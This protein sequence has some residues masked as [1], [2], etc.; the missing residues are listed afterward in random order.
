MTA[1][2]RCFS[3][4]QQRLSC[5]CKIRTHPPHSLHSG[6]REHEHLPLILLCSSTSP[7]ITPLPDRFL[8]P[9]DTASLSVTRLILGT[10]QCNH[11][12]GKP[13]IST[14]PSCL[15]WNCGW[16]QHRK[17]HRL[18]HA[19][20]AAAAASSTRSFACIIEQPASCSRLHHQEL[21]ERFDTPF[22]P[23]TRA[24]CGASRCRP[25]CCPN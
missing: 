17:R 20:P 1:A 16:P 25:L 23:P 13:Q 10:G 4:Q 12:I 7:L 9:W 19:A 24:T 11:D 2:A 22:Q 21:R 3:V 15:C 14:S 8:C 18:C 5:I 6:Q